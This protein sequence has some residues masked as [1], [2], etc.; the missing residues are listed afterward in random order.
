MKCCMCAWERFHDP[1]CPESQVQS[2]KAAARLDY[3]RGYRDG[4]QARGLD[5]AES[6]VYLLGFWRGTVAL[7][8]AENGH[9]PREF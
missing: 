7:E 2:L 6:S 9:D 4:R 5:R 8:E 1:T 3:Q